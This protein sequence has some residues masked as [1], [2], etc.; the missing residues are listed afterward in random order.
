MV[1]A[2]LVRKLSRKK[3]W[4]TFTIGGLDGLT[5]TEMIILEYSWDELKV[6]KMHN[7][8]YG[9]QSPNK[10]VDINAINKM[11]G[12]CL[13]KTRFPSPHDPLPRTPFP[14]HTRRPACSQDPLLFL[15]RP[16]TFKTR[17]PFW[18]PGEREVGLERERMRHRE[19]ERE[20]SMEKWKWVS[21]EKEA[22]QLVK[23]KWVL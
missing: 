8:I 23:R 9:S 7:F 17:L 4:G 22:G 18:A 15:T 13:A 3:T 2:C 6:F 11:M 19:R 14:C 5:F 10:V 1:L 20:T 16:A 21:W 12:T